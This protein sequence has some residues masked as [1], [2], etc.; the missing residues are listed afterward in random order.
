MHDQGLAVLHQECFEFRT[1]PYLVFSTNPTLNEALRK[2]RSIG[3][4]RCKYLAS[5]DATVLRA[6]LA[7][8]RPGSMGMKV[9]FAV[10]GFYEVP[11]CKTSKGSYNVCSR[12]LKGNPNKERQV[13]WF[14]GLNKPV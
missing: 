12:Y 1:Q 3:H 14:T 13:L 5:D 8:N 9:R 4:P 11:G 10:Y 7:G 6:D 2:V